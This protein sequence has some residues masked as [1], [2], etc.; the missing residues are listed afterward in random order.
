[1]VFVQFSSQSPALKATK[2]PRALSAKSQEE[3]DQY[4]AKYGLTEDSEGMSRPKT[5]DAMNFR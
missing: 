1:M 4:K 3:I 2:G 5:G